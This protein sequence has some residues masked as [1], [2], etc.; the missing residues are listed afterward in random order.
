MAALASVTQHWRNGSPNSQAK[1]TQH[2][3]RKSRDGVEWEEGGG[4]VSS[5]TPF[6]VVF[7][8]KL[9][10]CGPRQNANLYSFSVRSCLAS[11][12]RG[13]SNKVCTGRNQHPMFSSCITM[14]QSLIGNQRE[15]T[16][17]SGNK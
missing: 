6:L 4:G 10:C 1:F 8:V 3:P 11:E 13:A 2:H 12:H 7:S 17:N 5:G 9:V 14:Q 16:S 15:Q